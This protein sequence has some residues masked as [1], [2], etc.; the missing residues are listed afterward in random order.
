MRPEKISQSD[1]DL[2][3]GLNVKVDDLVTHFT[4]H[5][6]HHLIYT[7]ALFTALLGIVGGFVL[8]FL[9]S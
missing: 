2:L 5:L 3:L 9:K 4:N 8:N 1:H 7:L 6:H